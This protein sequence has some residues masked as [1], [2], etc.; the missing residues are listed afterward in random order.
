MIVLADEN[1]H[2]GIAERIAQAGHEVLRIADLAP[3][4]SDDDVLALA[5]AR[6]ALLVTNDTD[7]G[8]L[9][10]R[11][12]ARH[13]GVLLVRLGDMPYAEQAVLL[14]RTLAVHGQALRLAFS[15]LTARRLRIRS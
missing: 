11:R 1:L 3:S 15:V 14:E 10:Y 8:E 9:V 6:Q 13:A 12:S 5:V 2:Q 4:V 7:F